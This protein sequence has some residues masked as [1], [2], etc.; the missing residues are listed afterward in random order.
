MKK[1]MFV[2]VPLVVMA[3]MVGQAAAGPI[4]V[5]KADLDG[6]GDIEAVAPW[7]SSPPAAPLFRT[8]DLDK[9]GDPDLIEVQGTPRLLCNLERDPLPEAVIQHARLTSPWG[10]YSI[11]SPTDGVRHVELVFVRG[12]VLGCLSRGPSAKPVLV[13]SD[14]FFHGRADVDG[15]GVP[16]IVWE[17][18]PTT[19]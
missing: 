11:A 19:Q 14:P 1:L 4:A 6:D 3:L 13:V 10:A 9:D 12:Q 16:D 17:P 2:I 8:T 5:L 18:S 15:D 7:Q